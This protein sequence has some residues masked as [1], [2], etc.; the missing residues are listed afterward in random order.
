MPLSNEIIGRG[1]SYVKESAYILNAICFRFRIW[2]LL[3]FRNRG[4]HCCPS[5]HRKL[6][7]A[8]RDALQQQ[9]YTVRDC[10]QRCRITNR[11]NLRFLRKDY[12]FCKVALEYQ[13][14]LPRAPSRTMYVGRITGCDLLHR[15]IAPKCRF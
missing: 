8:H 7:I 10:T 11:S 5:F 3:C 12:T 14:Y 9:V 15:I 2:Y 13:L 4:F 6:R 1:S